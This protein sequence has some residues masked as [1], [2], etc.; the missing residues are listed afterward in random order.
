MKLT[1]MAHIQQWMGWK[2]FSSLCLQHQV[3]TFTSCTCR[4]K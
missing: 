2:C 1:E 4:E 3:Q